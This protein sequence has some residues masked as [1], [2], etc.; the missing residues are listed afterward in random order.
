MMLKLDECEQMIRTLN[1]L[2]DTKR[3]S[4]MK[5]INK[6]Q[7]EW[8]NM[9]KIAMTVEKDI[10]GPKKQEKDKTKDKIKKFEETLKEYLLGLKKEPFIFYKTGIDD[11]N[12][13][14]FDVE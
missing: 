12:R 7:E 1:L 9:L 10:S 5:E 14:I 6:L 3:E 4:E 8:K 13:R 2:G 11:S